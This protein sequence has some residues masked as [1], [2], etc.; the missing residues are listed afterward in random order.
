MTGQLESRRV[1]R[2]RVIVGAPP[3]TVRIG[4]GAILHVDATT[5]G[6]DH[7]H[8]QQAV[9]FW[10]EHDDTEQQVDR[11]FVV[12][13]TGHPIPDRARHRGTTDRTSHGLVWHLYEL[14]A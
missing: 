9:D 8:A 10:W 11:T 13:G 1:F 6:V 12:V 2:S 14:E 4:P 5:L 7:A 3:F